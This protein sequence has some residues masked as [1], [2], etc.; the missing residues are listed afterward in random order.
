[1]E[2]WPVDLLGRLLPRHLEIIYRINEEFLATVR[3]AF[4][5]DFLRERH[6]SIIAEEPVR[7]VRMAY[8]ATVAGFKVNGVAELHSEL[9]RDKVLPEFA[10]LYPEKF[11]NVT[12]GVTPR[13]F[14]RISNPGLSQLITEA[15]GDGW[16]T[17]LDR[18]R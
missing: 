7:S 1:L 4:P 13:R 8:L 16:L 17:N 11:T 18:L 2:V 10:Q 12:N 6:M 9:L 14:V 3:E 5:G 15:I